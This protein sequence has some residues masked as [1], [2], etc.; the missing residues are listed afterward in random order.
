MYRRFSRPIVPA[1]V[2]ETVLCPRP[3]CA[4]SIVK[5]SIQPFFSGRRELPALVKM[6]GLIN[7]EGH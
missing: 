3:P 6:A 5:F 7:S 4:S 1:L 2:P